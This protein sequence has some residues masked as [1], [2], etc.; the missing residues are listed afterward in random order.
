MLTIAS[1]NNIT[2]T[3]NTWPKVHIYRVYVR[4]TTQNTLVSIFTHCVNTL[5]NS[6]T[7]ILSS[8]GSDVILDMAL[9]YV[10]PLVGCS[11]NCIGTASMVMTNSMHTY[12]LGL[13]DNGKCY[14][15]IMQ[16]KLSQ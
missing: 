14:V 15:S 7:Y 9:K 11:A 16:C 1:N 5:Q 10:I 12:T 2:G 6:G 13:C 4:M 8:S 3:N